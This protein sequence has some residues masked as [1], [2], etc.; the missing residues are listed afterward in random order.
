MK[1]MDRRNVDIDI[2]SECVGSFRCGFVLRLCW[3]SSLRN[4]GVRKMVMTLFD[5]E[6]IFRKLAVRWRCVWSSTLF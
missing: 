2:G 3:L 6:W 4:D 5:G 1:W